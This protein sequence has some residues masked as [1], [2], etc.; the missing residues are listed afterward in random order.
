MKKLLFAI[1]IIAVSLMAE[2]YSQMTLDELNSLRGTVAAE[3]REAFRA[4]MQSRISEMTPE[5]QAAFR[6]QRMS[7]KN[8]KVKKMNLHKAS[9]NQAQGVMQRLKDGS[10]AGSMMQNKGNSQRGGNG[11]SNR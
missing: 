11:N 7:E 1:S 4:E 8:M 3:N 9:K 2:D 10:G 5:E 6:E